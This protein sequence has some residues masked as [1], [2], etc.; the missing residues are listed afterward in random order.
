VVNA[1]VA[2]QRRRLLELSQAEVARRIGVDRRTVIS[3]EAG[4]MQPSFENAVAWAKAIDLDIA[5]LVAEP[6][7][8]AAS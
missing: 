3:W 7:G 2:R 1:R 5:E 6:A 8:E 4:E